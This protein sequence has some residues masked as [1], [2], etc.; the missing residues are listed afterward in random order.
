[1]AGIFQKHIWRDSKNL[2]AGKYQK[3]NS[4]GQ[5]FAETLKNKNFQNSPKCCFFKTKVQKLSPKSPF[6]LFFPICSNIASYACSS[7]IQSLKIPSFLRY[8]T[9]CLL[10]FLVLV[11]DQ[12]RLT[13]CFN[14]SQAMPA[15]AMISFYAFDQF[16][17]TT[18]PQCNN[19]NYP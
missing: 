10:F 18:A 16:H 19:N 8:Y 2:L 3:S 5:I 15:A 1:M 17:S 4:G 13:T 14:L 12:N 6:S 11:I 7:W 9:F